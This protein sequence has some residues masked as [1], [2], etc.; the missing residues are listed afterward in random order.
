MKVQAALRVMVNTLFIFVLVLCMCR[1]SM[2]CPC[3]H[4]RLMQAKDEEGMNTPQDSLA[5]QVQAGEQHS[6]CLKEE[7]QQFAG[8][9]MIARS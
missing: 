2:L 4:H 6:L 9:C 1:V 7:V 8:G 3:T 5:R